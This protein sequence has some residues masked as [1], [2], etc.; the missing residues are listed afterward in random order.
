MEET[1]TFSHFFLTQAT[2][3]TLKQSWKQAA[4]PQFPGR[5]VFLHIWL[6]LNP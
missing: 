1:F 3:F 2:F 4:E 6:T 5:A